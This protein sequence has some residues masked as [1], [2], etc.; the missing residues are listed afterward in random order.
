MQYHQNLQVQGTTSFLK[1]E[2]KHF[3]LSILD[4]PIVSRVLSEAGFRSYDVKLA[5]LQPAPSP[6]RTRFPPVP[7]FNPEPGRPGLTLPFVDDNSRRVAEVLVRKS[8]KNPLLMGVYAKGAMKSFIELMQKGYGGALLPSEMASLRVICV[9]NEIAEFVGEGGNSEEK[10]RLRF[11]DLGREVEQCKGAGVVLSFGEVEVFVG[12][13]GVKNDDGVRFVVSGLTRLLEIHAGKV[14]L[15]GVAE[16]SGAYS[17]FLGL[18]PNVEKDWDL[19]LLT[20][21]SPTP[22]M[23]GLYPKSRWVFTSLAR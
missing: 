11:E 22:S 10:M 21:T 13:D 2:L 19:Q 14:W 23:E 6:S 12:D 17:K 8:K 16:T 1:V 4:D 7:H 20:V 9:E 3:V 5:L 15:M 18:F